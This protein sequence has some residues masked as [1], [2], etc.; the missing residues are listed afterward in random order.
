MWA[1]RSTDRGP[2]AQVAGHRGRPPSGAPGVAVTATSF[3]DAHLRVQRTRVGNL[4]TAAMPSARLTASTGMPAP[5]PSQRSTATP[6]P[7][8]RAAPPRGSAARI[9]DIAIRDVPP[10]LGLRHGTLDRIRITDQTYPAPPTRPPSHG[11]DIRHVAMTI[12][13]AH[14]MGS[15]ATSLLH[16][17]ALLRGSHGAWPFAPAHEDVHAAHVALHLGIRERPEPS[18]RQV[19]HRAGACA[20]VCSSDMSDLPVNW[21]PPATL[22]PFRASRRD[23]RALSHTCPVDHSRGDETLLSGDQARLCP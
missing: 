9:R 2:V 19:V 12:A 21:L 3:Q 6:S 11:G 23:R 16:S 17:R 13:G 8:T 10:T 15:W 14:G 20:D 7:D 1:T 5:P 18:S 22:R 4:R